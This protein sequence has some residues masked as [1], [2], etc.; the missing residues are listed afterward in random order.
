M[1]L[2]EEMVKQPWPRGEGQ[3]PRGRGAVTAPGRGR[4]AGCLPWE[5]SRRSPSPGRRRAG[6]VEGAL[7]EPVLQPR[8][9]RLHPPPS[10]PLGPKRLRPLPGVG[11]FPPTLCAGKGNAAVWARRPPSSREA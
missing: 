5:G 2:S 1:S 3:A 9:G 10:A 8:P 6:Q 7:P 4:R 11:S